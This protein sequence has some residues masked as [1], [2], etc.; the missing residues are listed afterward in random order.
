MFSILSFFRAG[1]MR[2]RAPLFTPCAAGLFKSVNETLLILVLR[3]YWFHVKYRSS[4]QGAPLTLSGTFLTVSFIAPHTYKQSPF[5]GGC[6]FF[7]TSERGGTIGAEFSFVHALICQICA[8]CGLSSLSADG[9]E[10][11]ELYK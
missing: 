7:N 10:R 11:A 5:A 6:L 4:R 9:A 8:I 1:V 2:W 3:F